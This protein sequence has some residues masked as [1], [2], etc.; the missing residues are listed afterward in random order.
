MAIHDAATRREA[1]SRYVK[2]QG[3]ETLSAMGRALG[4]NRETLR[5]WK[6]EDE[7]DARLAET[8]QSASKKAVEK[9]ADELSD[10]IAKHFKVD[11]EHLDVLDK[12]LF[13]H[14]IERDAN[15]QPV[16]GPDGLLRPNSKTTPA[17]LKRLASA[18]HQITVTRR[19][20]L[21]LPTEHQQVDQNVKGKVAVESQGANRLLSELIQ[22]GDADRV[23]AFQKM[24]EAY[25]EL[26]FGDEEQEKKG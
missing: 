11:S 18:R 15:G 20:I 21:G 2:S 9:M 22:R 1:L 19:M 14:L 5:K 17:E 6:K 26:L 4:V 10:Q 25:E 13:L 23:A 16:R 7:W 24:A 8:R 3:V 12:M